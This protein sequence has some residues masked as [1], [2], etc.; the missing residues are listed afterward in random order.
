MIRGGSSG[1][2]GAMTVA[3]CSIASSIAAPIARRVSVLPSPSAP[4]DKAT[5]RENRSSTKPTATRSQPSRVA[6][7]EANAVAAGPRRGWDTTAACR[8]ITSRAEKP[9]EGAGTGVQGWS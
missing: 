1:G 3:A 6:S 5:T 4:W 8:A 2:A 7:S 9:E